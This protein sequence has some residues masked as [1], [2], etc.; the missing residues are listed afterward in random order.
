MAITCSYDTLQEFH[1]K[2]HGYIEELQSHKAYLKSDQAKPSKRNSNNALDSGQFEMAETRAKC[3][4]Q[5]FSSNDLRSM[6]GPAKQDNLR[7]T[8]LVGKGNNAV[9]DSQ[10]S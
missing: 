10:A 1:Q 7:K 3:F 4:S 8:D 2:Q 9:D 6:I 5:I